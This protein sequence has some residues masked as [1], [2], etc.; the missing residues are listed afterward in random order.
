MGEY[1][2][3]NDLI[4]DSKHAVQITSD[5]E[6]FI[7][8]MVLNPTI[9]AFPEDQRNLLANLERDIKEDVFNGHNFRIEIS[10]GNFNPIMANQQ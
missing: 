9:T 3:K 4:L 10:D 7:L 6:S 2:K 1:F 5:H 8:R